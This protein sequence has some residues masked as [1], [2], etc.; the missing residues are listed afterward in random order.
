MGRDWLKIINL[1]WKGIQ[2]VSSQDLETQVTNIQN[3][4]KD[5]FIEALG[6]ITPFFAKL[7]V[8]P[9]AKPKFS[10]PDRCLLP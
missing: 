2:K 8:S 10:S 7:N 6:T 4:Y 5:V 3:K 9:D 1:D